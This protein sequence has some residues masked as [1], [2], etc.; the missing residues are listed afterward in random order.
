MKVYDWK[1][2]IWLRSCVLGFTYKNMIAMYVG[3]AK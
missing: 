1:K 2:V 3:S